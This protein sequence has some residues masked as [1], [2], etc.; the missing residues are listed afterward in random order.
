MNES[1]DKWTCKCYDL[2]K[3][4]PTQPRA[5]SISEA[6]KRHGPHKAS[7]SEIAVTYVTCE[8]Y[9]MIAENNAG[10][11]FEC[12]CARACVRVSMGVCVCTCACVVSRR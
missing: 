11:V 7:K 2:S 1:C 5:K 9:D 3:I 12:V 6:E 8:C 10:P 4:G